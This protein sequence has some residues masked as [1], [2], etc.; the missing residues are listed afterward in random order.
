MAS[1]GTSASA[2]EAPSDRATASPATQNDRRAGEDDSPDN[3]YPRIIPRTEKS[4][5]VK[6]RFRFPFEGEDIRLEL[7][8]SKSI[9]EGARQANKY[10]VSV[11]GKEDRD[12]REKYN[13]AFIEDAAQA[14]VLDNLHR[15]LLTIAKEKKLDADR[16]AELF[17][18]FVQNIEYDD[19]KSD[20]ARFPVETLAAEKGDCDDKSRLLI[21]LL[22]RSGFNVATFHFSSENHMAVGIQSNGLEYKNTGFSYIETTSPSM[23]GFPFSENADVQL[24]TVPAVQRIGTGKRKYGASPDVAFISK[25]L[26]YIEK[27]I[28]SDQKKLDGLNAKCMDAGEKLKELQQEVKKNNANNQVINRYNQAV[29]TYNGFVKKQQK[30]AAALNRKIDLRNFIINNAATRYPTVKSIRSMLKQIQ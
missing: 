19:A 17:T 11:A 14:P 15:K 3:Q 25:T 28:E 18:A 1:G 7:K 5:S 30:L 26:R 13:L 23:I 21:S 27:D 2:D 16:T 8:I 24:H 6:A 10:A 4:G 9:I 12:W 29:D 20:E 22:T